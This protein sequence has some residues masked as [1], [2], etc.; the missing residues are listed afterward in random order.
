ML[1]PDDT[2]E[3]WEAPAELIKRAFSNA[4]SNSL[5][6]QLRQ[7]CLRL[8]AEHD[9]R[10]WTICRVLAPTSGA[11]LL[12]SWL[13]HTMASEPQLLEVRCGHRARLHRAHA[14]PCLAG[15]AADSPL[16]ADSTP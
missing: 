3:A 6:T 4:P 7:A 1:M 9:Q 8:P 10:F 5:C 15:P 2:Q 14:L 12:R 11:T 13:L 16:L